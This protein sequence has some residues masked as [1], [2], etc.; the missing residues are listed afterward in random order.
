VQR[1]RIIYKDQNS[2]NKTIQVANGAKLSIKG[3]GL[4][5]MTKMGSKDK[6]LTIVPKCELNVEYQCVVFKVL[7][8]QMF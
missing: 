3:H 5:V 6:E 2:K 4:V 7:F 8:V 1:S